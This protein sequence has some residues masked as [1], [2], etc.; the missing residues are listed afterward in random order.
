LLTIL[1]C[2]INQK[3]ILWALQ[4]S[5]G[6]V[7]SAIGMRHGIGRNVNVWHSELKLLHPMTTMKPMWPG[8]GT[9]I[10]G[11]RRFGR[12]FGAISHQ[13]H[14]PLGTS[15]RDTLSGSGSSVLGQ[16]KGGL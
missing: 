15:L 10:A 5:P 7:Q 1:C 2:T 14:P 3:L 6:L 4:R 9:A 13:Q 8:L 16:S 11:S 12:K